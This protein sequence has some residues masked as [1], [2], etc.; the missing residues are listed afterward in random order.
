MIS[1]LLFKSVS[2]P[3]RIPASRRSASFA[4]VNT[5]TSNKQQVSFQW[6]HNSTRSRS[7][8]QEVKPP[9]RADWSR[10]PDIWATKQAEI[11]SQN[12]TSFPTDLFA[13]MFNNMFII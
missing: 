5:V 9:L 13:L 4:G 1:R 10:I 8:P 7:R 12:N 6:E 2:E 11:S 3:C